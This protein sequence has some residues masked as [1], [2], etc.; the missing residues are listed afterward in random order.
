MNKASEPECS[1]PEQFI[2]CT[3]HRAENTDNEERMSSII[4]ALEDFFY[5]VS[6][7]CSATSTDGK[8]LADKKL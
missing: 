6:G 1:I 2:L 4:E 3:V 8:S 7:C 5:V